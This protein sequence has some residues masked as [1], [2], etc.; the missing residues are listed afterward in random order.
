[1][2]GR[3]LPLR[4]A[5]MPARHRAN[6]TADHEGGDVAVADHQRYGEQ[7][8]QRQ[9]HEVLQGDEGTRLQHEEGEA[10]QDGRRRE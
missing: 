4:S 2:I 1:M 6:G 10:E 5:M 8:V 3:C 7:L 9:R